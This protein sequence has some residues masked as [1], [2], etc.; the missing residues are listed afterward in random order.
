VEEPDFEV[1]A[2]LV[3]PELFSDVVVAGGPG[4]NLDDEG[5]RLV[6]SLQ[7]GTLTK[8]RGDQ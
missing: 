1:A 5:Q 7:D 4:P 6:V 3:D 2:L 8:T